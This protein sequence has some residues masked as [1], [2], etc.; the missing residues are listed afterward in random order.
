[1]KKTVLLVLCALGPGLGGC[2]L[3]VP[4]LNNPN[5]ESLEVAPTP[6]SIAS[7][8]T[9]LLIGSRTGKATRTGYVLQL[10]ILGREAYSFDATDPR[11][12]TELLAAP[13][14]DPGNPT[15]GGNFWA[16]P[17]AN[18]RNA[19]ILMAALDKVSGLTSQEKEAIRGFA[20]SLQ[21]LEWMTLISTRDTHGAVIQE[22]E[23][24]DKPAPIESKEA[25]LA[26][27]SALLDEAKGH[28]EEGGERFPFPLGEGFEG[29]DTPSS[30]LRFNR[31]VK[32]R[33]EVYQQRWTEALAA[34]SE[35]FLDP[36]APL[37]RGVYH[38]YGAGSGDATNGLTSSNILA[39]PSLVTEADRKQ[40][41]MADER[42][43]RKLE[44]VEPRTYQGLTSRYVFTLYEDNTAPV[45]IIRNEELILLRAEA[46]IGLG[47]VPAA[48]D[49]LNFIRVTSGGLAPRLDLDSSNIVGEL[50]KQRRYSLLFEGGHHWIDMRRYGGL[51]QLPRDLPSHFVHERFPIPLE[52]MEARIR[53]QENISPPSGR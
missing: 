27:I 32:A 44:E 37:R 22:S 8:C 33:A 49:D 26:H 13:A 53:S 25:V 40:D 23:T 11:F 28:L 24:L 6:S 5:L 15:F 36:R 51:N 30:F 35:S 17:Y 21:A 2:S 48:A 14:L 52:E 47:N 7:A 1:M 4:D 45:P 29:F 20:K 12:V 43:T 42:V 9:G 41:G 16:Q 31:A 10:G 19:R 3:E 39:H 46:H 38:F 50:L 18:I 34:L